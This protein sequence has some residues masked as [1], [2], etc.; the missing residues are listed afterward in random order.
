MTE[1]LIVAEVREA[2]AKLM[3]KCDYDWD[4]LLAYLK[5]M[6]AQHPAKVVTTESLRARRGRRAA[7]PTDRSAS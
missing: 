4:K 2:R 7:P 5:Q 6:E 3:A 1:D